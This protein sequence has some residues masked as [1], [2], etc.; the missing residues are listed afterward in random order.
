MKLYKTKK[1]V[2]SKLQ[3]RVGS[4]SSSQCS[5][6]KDTKKRRLCRMHKKPTETQI[7]STIAVISDG[8]VEIESINKF[9]FDF[10]AQ[11]CKNLKKNV[12]FSPLAA[13]TSLGLLCLCS[14]Q[15]TRNKLKKILHQNSIE[16]HLEPIVSKL[17]NFTNQTDFVHM[18]CDL[19]A[20]ERFLTPK[21]T[22]IM[23]NY[24]PNLTIKKDSNSLKN[25]LIETNKN[26]E[27]QC[28]KLAIVLEATLNL[29]LEWKNEF[30]Y[31]EKRTF[32]K[33]DY[34]KLDFELMSINK[35]RFVGI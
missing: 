31:L 14:S 15:A 22:E 26:L 7:K 34:E 27:T 24:E 28:E 35:H 13:Y 4:S 12:T 33:S 32:T 29:S 3:Q 10:Y 1:N 30:T 16:N 8:Q 6:N 19:F 23:L 25:K 5:Q 21:Y 2:S 20:K 18:Q 17:V 11:T 9:S